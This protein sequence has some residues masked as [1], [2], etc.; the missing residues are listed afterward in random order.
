MYGT[1]VGGGRDGVTEKRRWMWRVCGDAA[2][3]RYRIA[4]VWRDADY[5]DI[6]E[7]KIARGEGW[8]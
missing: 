4:R 8:R 7:R 2:F 6:G 1:K 5:E 3:L